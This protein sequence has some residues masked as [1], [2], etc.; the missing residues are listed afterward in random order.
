MDLVRANSSR[1]PSTAAPT[2][3]QRLRQLRMS[4]PPGTVAP[5]RVTADPARRLQAG[6][7][8]AVWFGPASQLNVSS[9][10]TDVVAFNNRATGNSSKVSMLRGDFEFQSIDG[11]EPPVLGYVG[12]PPVPAIIF[13]ARDGVPDIM[14]SDRS[15]FPLSSFYG[16]TG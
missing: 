1:E 7:E 16:T 5:M 14:V 6:T 11:C 12:S 10:S 15:E 4:H 8:G 9:N 3:P 13:D 2:G